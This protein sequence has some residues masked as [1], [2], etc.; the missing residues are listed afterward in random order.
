MIESN[1]RNALKIIFD[2]SKTKRIPE[3]LLFQS[4]KKESLRDDS[5][6]TIE[7]KLLQILKQFA[8]EGIIKLPSEKGK[9]WNFKTQLPM[10][11]TLVKTAEEEKK[12]KD[13]QQKEA[14][15]NNT[16]WEPGKMI[17]IIHS[18]ACPN[19][20]IDCRKAKAVND[21]L[22]KRSANQPMIPA[23]ERA[24]RIFRDEKALDNVHKTGLFSGSISLEDL[25][26]FYCP[27]PI[28][29][30]PLSL[31]VK[32]TKGKPLLLVENANTYQSCRLANENTQT[33][34]ALVYGKGARATCKTQVVEGIPDIE[35]Q[36]QSCGIWYFGDLDPTGLAIPGTIN[37]FRKQANLTLLQAAIPLYRAL[38]VK[39]YSVPYQKTSQPKF[40]D[41]D[42]A[43]QWLGE[44]LA[45]LYLE[46]VECV[47]WPQE[48]L[49]QQDLE[50][51]FMKNIWLVY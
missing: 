14:I 18:R 47:R 30:H 43:I 24:L 44:D 25:D 7:K 33:F 15:I 23:R 49:S 16:S 26:C 32:K 38:I 3:Y 40:H 42:W 34:A 17:P 31:D 39:G 21:Y 35:K 36:L 27:E 41:K 51:V 37:E 45:E 2:T 11:I 13:K 29:F 6:L 20:L 19:K 4:A 1:I 50:L 10:E 46:R 22:L 5:D 8:A 12:R 48:G 9:K 28:P